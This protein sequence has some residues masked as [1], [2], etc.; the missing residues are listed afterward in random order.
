MDTPRRSVSGF[1]WDKRGVFLSKIS[2]SIRE[3]PD[4]DARALRFEEKSFAIAYPHQIAGPKRSILNAL[5]GGFIHRLTPRRMALTQK[6]KKRNGTIVDFLPHNITIA[7]QKAFAATTGDAHEKDAHEISDAVVAAIDERFG[8]T[9]FFPGVEDIQDLVET[10]L[11]E[12]GYFGVAKS[13]IIYRY[14]HE[15]IREERR[16]EV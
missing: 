4:I 10:A 15:K 1:V 16:Q 8:N 2:P 12:R 9:A 6:I 7:V 13:Y 5:S 14:E 3:N 11:M